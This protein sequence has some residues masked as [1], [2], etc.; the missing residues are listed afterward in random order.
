[1]RFRVGQ[2]FD[3]HRFGGEGPLVLGGVTV[4]H[5]QGLVAHS[6]GDVVLHALIDAILG[7]AGQGDI[8][9]WFPDNDPKWQNANSV[10]MLRAVVEA[11]KAQGWSIA[12]A[13]V[14]VICQSPKIAPYRLGMREI[15]AEALG[16]VTEQVNVKGTTTESLGFT[17]RK[18]GI[19]ACAVVL[20]ECQ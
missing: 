9:Q 14:T 13:D 2:G 10:E 11:V 18:E 6:D 3:V 15:I 8:G 19:A 7:A 16:V 12:N 4:P 20:L 5:A 17:G 1:M